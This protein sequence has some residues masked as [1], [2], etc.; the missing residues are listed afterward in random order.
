MVVTEPQAREMLEAI[1][2]FQVKDAQVVRA[3][4]NADM[5]IALTWFNTLG[6]NIQVATTRTQAKINHDQIESL[7]QSET[8]S[9]RKA[10]LTQ[11]LNEA[12]EK[13]KERKRNG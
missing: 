8:D 6:I 13:F 12:N 2:K 5:A 1:E 11:K 7:L 4:Q 3:Q 10:I 9:F